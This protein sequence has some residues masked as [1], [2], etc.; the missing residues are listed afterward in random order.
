MRF[1]SHYNNNAT[2]TET[3]YH[4]FPTGFNGLAEIDTDTLKNMNATLVAGRLPDGTKDEIAVSTYVCETF[5]RGGY[6]NGEAFN[7]KGETVY[8]KITKAADMVGKTLQMGNRTF[9]I[10]G[11]VD[12][13][14]DLSRY[15]P[16]IEEP[17]DGFSELDYLANYVLL[18]ELDSAT[19]YSLLQVAMVGEGY[20][21][22]LQQTEPDLS[23]TSRRGGYFCDEE[24]NGLVSDF[25][26]IGTL[27]HVPGAQITWLDGERTT[28]GEK[29]LVIPVDMVNW[30][31]LAEGES[32]ADYF[33]RCG[34]LTLE[35]YSYLANDDWL[36]DEGYTV[37]GLWDTSA[38]PELTQSILGS[39]R[40]F[41][42]FADENDGS[43]YFAMGAM[44]AERSGI[45]ALV[46]FCN[47]TD[48]EVRYEMNNS[49]TYQLNAVHEI[50]SELSTVFFWIGVGFAAFA[51]LML[52][53]F[54]GTSIAYKKQDI[55]IL[56]AI[57]SRSN[58]VF[59]IFFSE[60]FIIAA[61]NF[62]LS[63]IGV[64]TAT[65]LINHLLRQNYGLLITVLHFGLRQILL[66]FAVSLL[67]AALAS[68]FP[69]RRI[70]AKRPIDA[71]RNR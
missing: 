54:I 12:T 11:V 61:I 57:G 21:T 60:S 24:G 33:R 48:S 10:T 39:E 6:T 29:E 28:L 34:T 43:F 5:I 3:D 19:S 25:S 31:E 26:Y 36:T 4:I 23:I 70:A 20:I 42:L 55:G 14:F 30:V 41:S 49:V 35:S 69:V 17:E 47:R 27:A 7:E 1:Y 66:L 16:L 37:V 71:I 8:Q 45:E 40:L 18:N 2:F 44:P 58:D 63:S 50:L 51:A 56:R 67:V 9:T 38:Y 52:A 62:L 32:L 65:A 59:R 15:L 22:R 46:R 53:N 13:G 68:F 64:G